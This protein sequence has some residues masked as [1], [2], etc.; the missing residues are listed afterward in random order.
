MKESALEVHR[1]ATFHI[2]SADPPKGGAAE[3]QL[4]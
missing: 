4:R 2:T 3:R 1:E